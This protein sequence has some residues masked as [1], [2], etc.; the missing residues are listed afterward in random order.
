MLEN[1][2]VSQTIE[3]LILKRIALFAAARNALPKEDLK[4]I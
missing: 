2:C 1:S 3:N 4:K